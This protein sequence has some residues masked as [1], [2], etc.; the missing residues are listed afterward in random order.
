M[1]N[2]Q[3]SSFQ[4]KV[5]NDDVDKIK[6]DSCFHDNEKVEKTKMSKPKKP[7]LTHQDTAKYWSDNADTWTRLVREGYD[8]YRDVVNTPAFMDALPPVEGLLGLDVGCGEGYNTRMVAKHGAKMIAFD[9]VKKFVN[10]SND[11]ERKEDP[12]GIRF[13]VASAVEIPFADASF[14]FAIS[15]MCLMDMPEPE[16]AM[17]EVF[18]VLKPDGWFQF[19]ITHPAFLH[20]GAELHE[21]EDGTR[22]GANWL[23]DENGKK[24]GLVIEN[25]L[26]QA[27]ETIEEWTFSVAP[28][29]VR[30]SVELFKVPTFGKTLSE[31]FNAFVQAGFRLEYVGEP[32]ADAETAAKN[33]GVADTQIVP[34][35][36]HL[37]GRKS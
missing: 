19:S 20:A 7:T 35:F 31:W 16:I 13:G 18:R 5:W 32:H 8:V 11:T 9:M 23:R 27:I 24:T 12:L 25:Y 1:E 33:P 2:H 26:N 30:N 14:D 4:I 29:E 21:R 22:T 36:M 17:Q 37:R 34:I 3:N 6:M 15:T 28:E 10:Y